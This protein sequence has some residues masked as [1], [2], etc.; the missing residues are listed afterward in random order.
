[1]H[2]LDDVRDIADRNTVVET[3]AETMSAVRMMS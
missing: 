1:M 2:P 3:C